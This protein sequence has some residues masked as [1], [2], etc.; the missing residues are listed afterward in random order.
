[1]LT[2]T[3]QDNG[4]HLPA[5]VGDLLML[6]LAEN[7]TSGYRWAPESYD[8]RLLEL[9]EATAAYPNA[10]VGSG[11]EAIFRFRVV[12]AGSGTLALK[13]WRHWE[14]AG[15][16]TQRFAVTIDATP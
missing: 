11:G 9:V 15:S 2:V 10:A 8:T 5:H 3:D 13:Y 1:M 4:R 16:I 14:G 6:H 12:G 7:A